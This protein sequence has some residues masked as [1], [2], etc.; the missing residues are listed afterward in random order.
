MIDYMGTSLSALDR[1]LNSYIPKLNA[2][3]KKALLSVAKSYL[4]PQQE[5]EPWKD[6]GFISEMDRRFKEMESGKLKLYTLDE[7]EAYTRGSYKSRKRKK[8]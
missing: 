3:Q 5:S 7:A 8:Q 6:K 2:T 4:E 1:Q